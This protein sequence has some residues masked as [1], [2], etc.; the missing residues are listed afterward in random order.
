MIGLLRAFFSYFLRRMM[1]GEEWDES[2]KEIGIRT[3]KHDKFENK[4][5]K[6]TINSHYLLRNNHLFQNF[7]N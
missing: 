1:H 6:L 4:I 5:R 7:E 2:P 3:R